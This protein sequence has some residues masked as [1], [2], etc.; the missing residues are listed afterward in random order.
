MGAVDDGAGFPRPG[1]KVPARTP[2]GSF[3]DLT[4][5]EMF[6]ECCYAAGRSK[7]QA[8]ALWKRKEWPQTGQLDIDVSDDAELVK[9]L[10]EKI[11]L[12][13]EGIDA[14]NVREANVH[15]LASALNILIEKRQLLRGKPTSILSIED[16]RTMQEVGLKLVEEMK[17]RGMIPP[18]MKDIT[19]SA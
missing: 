11:A 12:V 3:I 8:E 17:R 18:E 5:R 16:R 14:L 19:P 9:L 7:R 2:D 13:S 6:L 4:V 10:D 15:Q 1:I